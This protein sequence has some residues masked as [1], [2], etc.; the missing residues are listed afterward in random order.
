M[1]RRYARAAA[2]IATL[3]AA[4]TAAAGP[5]GRWTPVS[6]GSP[7]GSD[8]V[9][10]ART[11]DGVLH[12]AWQ[13][14][15]V[16]ATAYWH[17]LIGADGQ[18][19]GADPIAPGLSDGG[20]P[21]LTSGPDGT[22]RA[23]FFIRTP[24]GTSAN[25][26][27]AAQQPNGPWSVASNPLAQ[28]V[29]SA[30]PSVGAGA[31]RDGT[32]VVAWATGSRVRYRVGVD[33]GTPSVALGAGG[34]C[35]LGAQ[36]AVDQVTGQAYVAWASTAAGATGV[37]VQ[38]VDRSGADRPRVFATGSANKKRDA[39][40]LPDGRVALAARVGNPGV[41]LAYTSGFPKVRS[42]DLLSVG[43]R[44]LVR[45]VKAPGASHVMLASGAQGRLWLAWSRGATI[46]AA[47]TNRDA[48]RLGAIR[49][50]P[51]RKGSRLVD[52]LQGDGSGGPLDVV[53][54]LANR[55]GS[56]NVW[57]QQVLPGLTLAITAGAPTGGVTKYVFR[58]TDAGE[59]VEN[60]TVKVGKQTLTTGQAGTVAL[61]T[62]DRPPNATASKLG[63]A[64]ATTPLP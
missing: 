24:D 4:A 6:K 36:A 61:A 26:R 25:L 62:G 27:L 48:T 20:S 46:F 8:E 53:A 42:I 47:R 40:V 2:A 17:T 10:I 64:P 9:G 35:A 16:S 23:F 15:G 28:A 55:D 29:G 30:P 12:V 19:T 33:P 45:S 1:R 7:T 18:T 22:L 13:R 63:Y 14:R 38:A 58:V 41:Y 11:P 21:A 56:A 52:E 44:T 39:A 43:A 34:C 5:P 37:Y 3:L 57:H 50:I 51:L 60:A 54:N 31:A 32:P 49:Q 59:P